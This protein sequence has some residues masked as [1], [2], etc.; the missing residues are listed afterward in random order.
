M[1]RDEAQAL[2]ARNSEEH[3]DR[4]T[5]QWMP[6]EQDDGEWTVVSLRLPKGAGPPAPLKATVETKPKPPEPDDPRPAYWR[7]VGGPWVG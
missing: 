7:N 5:H 6:R 1:T 2:C 3:P 4:A